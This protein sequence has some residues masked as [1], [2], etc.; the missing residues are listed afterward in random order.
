MLIETPVIRVIDRMDMPSTSMF[1]ICAL[2]AVASLFMLEVSAK[3][4]TN[5]VT[6]RISLIYAAF[7]RLIQPLSVSSTSSSSCVFVPFVEL[8]APH[9]NWR[10]LT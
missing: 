3:P 6:R 7:F 10:L 1:R 9:N 2:F 5:H 8:Q 4:V